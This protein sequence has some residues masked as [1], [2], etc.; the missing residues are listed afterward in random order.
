MRVLDIAVR[1]PVAETCETPAVPCAA[2]ASCL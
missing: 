1:L 2:E